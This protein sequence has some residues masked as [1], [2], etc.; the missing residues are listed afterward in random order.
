[1]RRSL[2]ETVRFSSTDVSQ[3]EITG[4][5]Q[6][7]VFVPGM[8]GTGRLYYRQTPLLTGRFRV[9]TYALRD[10]ARDMAV[11]VDDLHRVIGQVAPHGQKVTLVGESFGGAL[12]MSYVLAY[13]ERVARLV[14][15]NSFPR[16]RSPFQLR[17]A[18]IG[19][20]LMPWRMMRLIRRFAVRRMHSRHTPRSEIDIFLQ[21]TQDVTRRAYASRLRI[22]MSY[23]LRERLG[24]IAVPTLFL[25]AERDRLVSSVEEATFMAAKVPKA[26]LRILEGHGHVSLIAP[27]V[28]LNEILGEWD[29]ERR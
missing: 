17:L 20:H 14:V 27:G 29:R 11:L 5:G 13:P 16:Y 2:A 15:L 6:P 4:N 3:L 19:I 10:D 21:Q 1:M 9:A 28:D 24:E 23:D 25:A 7:L 18:R 26:T 8:D 12:A 22:L